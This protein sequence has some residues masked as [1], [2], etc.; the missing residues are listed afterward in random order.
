MAALRPAFPGAQGASEATEPPPPCEWMSWES[1]P[2]ASCT[3]V[4]AQLPLSLQPTSLPAPYADTSGKA[5]GKVRAVR[6]VGA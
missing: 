4:S 5:K 6:S 2:Q 3:E 1:P